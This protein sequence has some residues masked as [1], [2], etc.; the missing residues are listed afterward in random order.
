[1]QQYVV[2]CL[3]QARRI[4]RWMRTEWGISEPSF[5]QRGGQSGAVEAQPGTHDRSGA[6]FEIQI[7]RATREA[8]ARLQDP[9]AVLLL[10]P[11]CKRAP[12]SFLREGDGS[13][14]FSRGLGAVAGAGPRGQVGNRVREGAVFVRATRRRRTVHSRHNQPGWLRRTERSRSVHTL[15]G[16]CMKQSGHRKSVG[17]TQPHH[18]LKQI[19]VAE[20]RCRQRICADGAR[21]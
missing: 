17:P 16:A 9:T 1:M 14:G 20:T 12:S 4:A 18:T 3:L 19:H 2:R 6:R 15:G 10:L 5:K 11:E 21:Q 7:V 8:L 13:R